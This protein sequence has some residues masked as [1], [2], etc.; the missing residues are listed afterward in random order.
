MVEH[1]KISSNQV[2][3]M[4]ISFLLGSSILLIPSAV[5]SSARQDAWL[6][7]ILTIA[8][9]QAVIYNYAT[10]SMMFPGRTF[11]QYSREILGKYPGMLAGLTITWFS[12]HLGSLVVR[13][14]GDLLS[15]TVLPHTP[16]VVTDSIII[17][18]V[19]MG[20]RMGVE[21]LARVNKLIIPFIVLLI[22]LILVLGIPEMEFKRLLPVME[23]GIKPVIKGSL[24]VIGFPYAETVLFTMIIPFLNTPGKA[25]KALVTGGLAGGALLFFIVIWTLLVLGPASTARFWFPVLEAV[26][27]IDIFNIIQRIESIIIIAWIFLGFLKISVCFYSFVLGLAQ[28]FNLKDYRPLVLPAGVLM[29]ALSQLVYENYVEEAYF[30]S[31]IWFPYAMVPGLI[32]PLTMLAV[33]VIRELGSRKTEK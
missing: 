25:R 23:S 13:N 4:I 16:M 2:S 15:A 20:T 1:G 26:R 7:L 10:L 17:I 11:V 8:A 18:L 9:G 14:F 19:I 33:A 27:V 32:L 29:L 6:S 21:V 5:A 24:V 3:W 31:K 30:A 12:L 28:L 22:L